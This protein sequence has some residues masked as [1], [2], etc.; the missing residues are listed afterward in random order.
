MF[1]LRASLFACIAVIFSC[2]VQAKYHA[3][4]YIDFDES[5]RYQFIQ[6]DEICFNQFNKEL[7]LS[8]PFQPLLQGMFEGIMPHQLLLIDRDSQSPY[9][10]IKS[11]ASYAYLAG[12]PSKEQLSK[13]VDEL[14]EYAGVILICGESLQSYFVQ[15]GFSI[16]P[17]MEFEYPIGHQ[18]IQKDL[19]VGFSIKPLDIA[20]FKQ[21]SWFGFLSLVQGGAQ[22]FLDIGFG[23]ALVND[24][25]VSVAQ[26]Y[27]AFLGN[28]LCEIGVV[29]HPDYRGNGYILHPAI[30]VIQQCLARNLKPMWSCNSENV[31][32][33]KTALKLG[34]KIK[35]H[36]AFLKSL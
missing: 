1:N 16:Q 33:Y 5:F 13:I 11:T 30:A 27:G 25:G 8:L 35:R 12:F 7:C 14:A 23:F 3:E 9:V 24:E 28:G 31:A 32:S 10:L 19:P 15:H 34:F 20:L 6:A 22:R 17:R 2:G 36:Y 21:S 26:A 18:I 29:T 4:N